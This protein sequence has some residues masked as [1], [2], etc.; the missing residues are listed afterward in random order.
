MRS[1]SIHSATVTFTMSRGAVARTV[2]RAPEVAPQNP[3]LRAGPKN[4]SRAA[5]V[6]CPTDQFPVGTKSRDLESSH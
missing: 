4:V 3:A 1:R 2:D 6:I 5:V